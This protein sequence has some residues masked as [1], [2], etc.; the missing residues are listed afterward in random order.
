[1]GFCGYWIWTTHR[2]LRKSTAKKMKRRLRYLMRACARGGAAPADLNA[3]WQSYRGLLMHCNS[4]QLKS[5][6]EEQMGDMLSER[7]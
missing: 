3:S 4:Y 5:K 1:V 7:N 2:K 6:L